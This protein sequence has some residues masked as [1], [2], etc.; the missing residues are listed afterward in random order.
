MAKALRRLTKTGTYSILQDKLESWNSDYHLL[1]CDQNLNRCCEVIELNSKVQ[2]Q[3]F[4][5]L[6]L[7]AGEGG[8]NG[9]VDTLK[10]RLLPWLGSCFSM[11]RASVC[12]TKN[13]RM[14]LELTSRHESKIQHME[15]QLCSTQLQLDSTRDEL[16]E[17]QTKLQRNTLMAAATEDEIKQLRADLNVA[18][19][20][21]EIYKKKLGTI[22]EYE[23]QI[24]SL[25]KEMSFLNTEKTGL[26]E[27]LDR[28]RSHSPTP[29]L[30]RTSSPMR[31]SSPIRSE[32]PSRAQL[33]P[34]ARHARLVARFNDLYA[35]E[36]LEA[37]TM[38]QRYVDNSE[39][40]QKIIF[41]AVVESFRVAKQAYL[42]FKQR[43]RKTLASTHFGP[44]SLED[45]TIDYIVR[46]MDLYDV[47]AS[48]NDVINAMHE[49]PRISFL[50][51]TDLVLL[52]S[53]IRETSKVAFAMQTL[54]PPLDVAFASDGEKYNESRYRRSHD[55]DFSAPLIVFHVWP[56]LTEGDIVLVKGEAVTRRGVLWRSSNRSSTLRFRSLSPA[57]SLVSFR[58]M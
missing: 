45:A 30:S 10:S 52:S 51:E 18:R 47:Q 5:I 39:M 48:V 54:E 50:P 38:L 1:S 34:S 46:N 20:E 21:A 36:R 31:P 4:C 15:T 40:V 32:S 44:E 37:Q 13:D 56:A 28:C 12:L 22:D 53:L 25:R 29:R 41:F 42:N 2:S 49:N 27:R 55:S 14:L 11:A 35:V 9:G 26:Q 17:S 19:E 3:L 33:T 8:Q 23:E 16:A 57:R 58:K 6:N 7:T 24:R 43:V